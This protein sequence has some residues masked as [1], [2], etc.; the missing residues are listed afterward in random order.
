[1]PSKKIVHIIDER[2]PFSQ[3]AGG[4][5]S[6][7]VANILVCHRQ[8]LVVCTR[9]DG[10][11]NVPVQRIRA[12]T[13]FEMY[14][15]CLHRIRTP[16]R[17]RARVA[18]AILARLLRD[19]A[20]GDVV[21]IHNRPEFCFALGNFVA[22]RRA[23]LVLHLHNSVLGWK[24]DRL[25]RSLKVDRVVYCSEYLHQVT[26]AKYDGLGPASVIYNG[27]D[28]KLFRP[29][30]R[31]AGERS[32]PPLVL[33]ASR[34][35]PEKGAH[36]L[37]DAVR[38]LNERNVRCQVKI[39]GSIGFGQTTSSNYAAGLV[40][41]APPNVQFLGYR[42]SSEIANMLRE[43]DIFCLPSVW[44]DPFPLAPLEA[45]ASG[46]AVVATRSGGIPEAFETSGALLVEKGCPQALA[47][48]LEA[49]LVNPV[50]LAGVSK[51]GY[52][53]FQRRFTWD[54]VAR[55]YVD[56]LDGI[57]QKRRCA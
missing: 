56:V 21:W 16:V 17:V 51:Q 37:I 57:T 7:W 4:A 8:S 46:V 25:L 45:M 31:M 40:A 22:S 20:P 39:I 19:L 5:I 52:V 26:T 36:V 30:P 49:L 27:A 24:D 11:W 10:S 48:A 18:G 14:G 43:A 28:D 2:E 15:R 47:R 41:A 44:D 9:S 13:L 1:M 42:A 29:G 50:L 3:Y 54:N 6:R 23:G 12:S 33:V 53:Q 34:L 38:L 35:V 32:S 55:N